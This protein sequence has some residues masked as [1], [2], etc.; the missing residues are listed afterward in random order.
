MSSGA[1]PSLWISLTYSPPGVSVDGV[2]LKTKCRPSG[3]NAGP[4]TAPGSAVNWI[5]STTT[6]A[7]PG[8]VKT[9]A[10]AIA[11]TTIINQGSAPAATS[12]HLVPIGMLTPGASPDIA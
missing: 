4:C 1:T 7:R 9:S 6:G 10:T 11:T 12:V 2:Q 8:T 5:G 3:E